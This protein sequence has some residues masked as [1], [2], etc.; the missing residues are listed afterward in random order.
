MIKIDITNSWLNDKDYNKKLIKKSNEILCELKEDNEV[1]FTDIPNEI[2]KQELTK[3]KKLAKYYQD[4]CDVFLVAGIGGSYLGA[5]S[6][7]QML[8]RKPKVEVK[9]VG[10]D[11]NAFSILETL[12]ELKN[13]D[14]CVNIISKSGTTTETLIAFELI[15]SFMKKKYKNNDEYKNRIIFTTDSEKGYL[16]NLCNNENYQSLIVPNN[17][18]GRYSVL[19]NVGLLPM[20]VAGINIENVMN[21][22]KNAFTYC[23]D[24]KIENNP[25]MKYAISRYLLHSKKKKQ[26]EVTATFDNRFPA[27]LDWHQQLFAESEGKNQKGLFVSTAYYSTDL[28]SI[29]QFMQEGTPI[30]FETVFNVEQP[31]TDVKLENLSE[32][33]PIKYLEGK[34]LSDVNKSAI[35]GTIDAHSKENTP[36]LSINLDSINETTFGELVFTLET[37]CGISA[38]LI[39]VNPFNQPGVESYKK[40]MKENLLKK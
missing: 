11:F 17:V 35:L 12:K 1:G 9:F 22:A 31:E 15:L 29:G 2:T 8:K 40:R 10:L 19:T 39:N 30:V 36:V 34:M 28:H 21:G 18:G 6:A 25:A 14:V 3:I 24:S 5:Y 33:S 32:N 38:K 20:A 37:A 27:F 7:I 4:K 13:K 23:F 26:I 16:R